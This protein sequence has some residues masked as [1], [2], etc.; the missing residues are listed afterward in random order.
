LSAE[1]R[2]AIASL[3]GKAR[4]LSFHAARRIRENFRYVAAIE[5]LRG[6]RPAVTRMRSF[7]GPL[8]GVTRVPP[9][10]DR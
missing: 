2:I 10:R 1:E 5:G 3:G 9:S 4:S 6:P 8:P 7:T